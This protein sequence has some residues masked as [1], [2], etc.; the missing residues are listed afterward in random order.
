MQRAPW[1][2]VAA[3]MFTIAWGGNQFTPLLVMYRQGG[4][5]PVVV[6]FLLFAYVVGIVP[7]L[8]I[9]GPLS[10]RIGRRAL[11][12]PAPWITV[13]GSL[14]LALGGQSPA[15]LAVGRVLCGAAL[16]IAMAAGGS[17]LK[18]LS[19]PPFDPDADAIAG[20]RRQGMALT[21]GFAIGAV[22]A[23]LLAQ[24]APYPHVTAYAVHIA[25]TVPVALA[26][27]A[28][29]DTGS[30]RHAPT[31]TPTATETG[32]S[33]AA[34]LRSRR[35]V[36][37]VVPVAPWV[38]GAAGVAYAIVPS[39]LSALTSTAA[40]AFSGLLCLLTLG[41][42]FFIQ[43][44][45]TRLHR[46]G[47]TRLS[48]IAC[49]F[50]TAGMILAALTAATAHTAAVAI[51]TGITAAIILGCGYGTALQACL[52]EI[53]Q[54]ATEQN[55]AALT[56]VLYSLAYIGFAFPMLLAA[57]SS[58]WSYPLMLGVGATVAACTM[59]AIAGAR[60]IPLDARHQ[61]AAER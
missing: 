2:V 59:A 36:L 22:C 16:G 35:F 12:L 56:A 32:L 4:M 41:S 43:R 26:L 30:A 27:L 44:V 23:A 1:M 21:S 54:V 33:T 29:P 13:A 3:M 18:E 15:L 61:R 34:A 10:D 19:A 60:S 51:P 46:P 45:T 5:D 53:Q 40:I 31:T 58:Q 7:A 49:A 28:V 39:V 48:L 55:L 37:L 14:C 47:S 17:W 50:L 52:L 6:D 9:C 11:C 8:A 42:G 24:W 20:V 38:F 25:V 57:L